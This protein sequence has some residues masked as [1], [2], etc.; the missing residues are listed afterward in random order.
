MA[1]FSPFNYGNVLAQGEAIKGA[2]LQNQAA[3]QQM[4]PNS[5]QNQLAREQLQ[6]T[7]QTG[8]I[9]AE[10]NRR[11]QGKYD[12]DTQK[13]NTEWLYQATGAILRDPRLLAPVGEEAKRRGILDP[14]FDITKATMDDI[15][16][17]NEQLGSY[18]SKQETQTSDYKNYAAAKKEGYKGTFVDYQTR[19]RE[20]GATNVTTTVGPTSPGTKKA[21]E[22]YAEDYIGWVTG[23]FSDTQKGLSQLNNA[24]EQLKS[25]EVETG[26]LQGFTPDAVKAVANPKLLALRQNVEEVVQRNLRVILGAQF[27]EKE[28]ERL[29]ARAFDDKLPTAENIARVERLIQQI[30]DA[31]QAKQE[32]AAY[33]L[34]NKTLE[35]FTGK[36]YSKADFSTMFEGEKAQGG[37]TVEEVE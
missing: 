29:I 14:R 22:K 4:D 18:F 25:G 24:L 19:L 8:D 27:T 36:T 26:P 11:E 20:S 15:K 13:A 17:I 5:I 34:K 23:G 12:Q 10:R 28:G 32:A 6:N 2:R 31:A 30:S 33:F 16:G 21:D 35:G 7:R 1:Q 3:R 37:W 9:A